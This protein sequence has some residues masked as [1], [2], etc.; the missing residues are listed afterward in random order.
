LIFAL[1]LSLATSAKAKTASHV[2][3]PKPAPVLDVH[4]TPLRLEIADNDSLRERGLSKRSTLAWNRGMLFVFPSEQER[5]FWMID[6]AF[7]LDIAYLDGNGVVEDE[8]TMVAE[9]GVSPENLRRYPS[10]S[11]RVQYAL[12]VNRGW[13]A[14]HALRVGDTLR[15]V[16]AWASPR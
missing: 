4:G 6:C 2:P 15:A 7:D 13:L 8:Q 9:P 1:L 11:D 5:T 14:A 12:E 10:A 3:A 16:K